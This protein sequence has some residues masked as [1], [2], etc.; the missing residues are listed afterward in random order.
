M[1]ETTELELGQL[2]ASPPIGDQTTER[3]LVKRH[4]TVLERFLNDLS[5]RGR[6][7]LF[8]AVSMRGPQFDTRE[9]AF[10]TI[11]DDRGN[12]PLSS[13]LVGYHSELHVFEPR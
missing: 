12:I 13:H 9:P 5:L 7:A 8:N 2:E 3:V 10:Q 6:H 11:G 1:D 4:A